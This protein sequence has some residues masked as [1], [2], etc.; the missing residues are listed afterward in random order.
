MVASHFG[1][2]CPLSYLRSFSHLT[3]EGVSVSG[4][5]NALK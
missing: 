1:K 4:I 2:E 5:R 3:R